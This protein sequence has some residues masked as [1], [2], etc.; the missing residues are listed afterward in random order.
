MK[1]GDKKFIGHITFHRL[2]F[3]FCCKE[4]LSFPPHHSQTHFLE[5]CFYLWNTSTPLNII[6]GIMKSRY[7]VFEHNSLQN[8]KNI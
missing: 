3:Y 1:E 5:Q 6:F 8:I 4:T 2:G 7:R